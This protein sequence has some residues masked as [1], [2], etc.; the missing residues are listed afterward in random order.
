MAW[1]GKTMSDTA[2]H[3]LT[4]D[5]RQFLTAACGLAAIGGFGTAV[6]AQGIPPM[7]PVPDT[8]GKAMVLPLWPDGTPAGGYEPQPLPNGWPDAFVRN[9][10]RPELHVFLPKV[11]N[12]RA[13][14]S[15]PGGA[16]MVVSIVNEGLDIAREMT[17]RGYT[18]FVL[19]YRLPGEG[20]ADRADVPLQDAQR[21]MRIIRSNASRLNFDPAAV[22]AVGFSAGGHLGATLATGF[23]ERVY[24]TRDAVDALDARPNAVGLIYPV[25]SMSAPETH[26]DSAKNL[27]GPNPDPELILRR[28]PAHH[29]T[30]ETPPVFLVHAIDDPAVPVDNSLIMMRAL[31]NAGRPVEA[32]L[33]E[34]GGHGFGLGSKDTPAGRWIDAFAA[35]LDQHVARKG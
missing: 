1:M 24:S 6:R 12:G 26:A 7:P 2:L 5:R 32:H 20:W 11:S 28:S 31:R 23:S 35:W 4:P 16:Y 18:V 9:V 34:R 10:A 17:A 27:L 8:W 22:A 3:E 14:L 13:L 19:T 33:F 15:I 21:A 29:V 30:A 25:I